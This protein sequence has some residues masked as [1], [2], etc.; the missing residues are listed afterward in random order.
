MSSNFKYSIRKTINQVL[1]KTKT[2]F[3]VKIHKITQ[4]VVIPI[5]LNQK[6]KNSHQKSLKTNQKV[7]KGASKGYRKITERASKGHQN[8]IKG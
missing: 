8:V 7:T 6:K 1:S 4:I 3:K 5:P 2:P